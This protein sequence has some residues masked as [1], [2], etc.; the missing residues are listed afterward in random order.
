M[1]DID[2]MAAEIVR[3]RRDREWRD[4]S[5]AT[6]ADKTGCIVAAWNTRSNAFEVGEAQYFDGFWWWA[7]QGPG[8]YYARTITPDKFQPLPPPPEK[9]KT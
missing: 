6:D 9:E 4:I 5:E 8:D 7:N 2:E 1:T 3:L